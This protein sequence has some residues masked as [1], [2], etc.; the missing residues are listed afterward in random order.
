MCNRSVSQILIYFFY[1]LFHLGV[2]RCA[3][4]AFRCKSPAPAVPPGFSLQSLTQGK[5]K[6]PQSSGKKQCCCLSPDN[7][8]VVPKT[9]AYFPKPAE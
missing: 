9:V 3:G 4:R 6:T 1:L 7:C 2:S 8:G 5:N